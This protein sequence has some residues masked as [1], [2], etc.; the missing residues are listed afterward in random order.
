[1]NKKGFTL[2]EILAVIVVLSLVITITATKGFGV[3]DNTKK[4]ITEQNK[5]AIEEGAKVFLTEVMYCD[6]ETDTDLLEEYYKRTDKTCK[7]LQDTYKEDSKISFEYLKDHGY[8]EGSDLEDTNIYNDENI[9]I[10]GS[11]N[12]GKIVV[13]LE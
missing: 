4:A 8:I 1:M 10:R 11:I 12:N 2:V 5:K 7:D 6:D 13:T 9:K 3:F